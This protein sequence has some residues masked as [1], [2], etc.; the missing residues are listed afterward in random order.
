VFGAMAAAAA[1]K[2]F[3]SSAWPPLKS[4]LAAVIA[5]C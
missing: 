2:P 3:A 4:I 1:T 5:A